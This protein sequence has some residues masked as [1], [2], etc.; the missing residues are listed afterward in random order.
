MIL[1]RQRH[2]SP[3]F[4]VRRRA[5]GPDDAREHVNMSVVLE[6]ALEIVSARDRYLASSPCRRRRHDT[7]NEK[8]NALRAHTYATDERKARAGEARTGGWTRVRPRLY[9]HARRGGRVGGAEGHAAA[10]RG[11]RGA[12]AG[13]LG[14][15]RVLA[16]VSF[17]T[18]RADGEMCEVRDL[19]NN[20]SE[21]V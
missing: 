11:G 19:G 16:G 13:L 2:T 4:P 14:E 3:S 8:R 15:G 18:V 6:E 12:V 21:L 10:R 7:T 20:A 9:G 1:Y 5:V 17:G